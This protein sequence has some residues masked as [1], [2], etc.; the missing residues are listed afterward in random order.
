M[1]SSRTGF[2]QAGDGPATGQIFGRYRLGRRIARGGMAEIYEATL[3]GPGGFQRAVA[4]KRLHSHLARDPTFVD[5]LTDE[6]RLSALLNHPNICQVLDFGSEGETYYIAMERIVGKD[7]ARV[8][9]AVR[10]ARTLVPIPIGVYV[11]REVAVGLAYAHALTSSSGER[12]GIVHRDISPHNIM[13]SDHGEVKICDF[14]IA[15]AESRI[16]QTEAGVLKGKLCYMAPEQ[17]RGEPMDGK[18]D[19]FAAGAVLYEMLTGKE[20]YPRDLSA[21]TVRRVRSA[22]FKPA[23]EIRPDISAALDAALRAAMDADPI[24]RLD[25]RRFAEALGEHLSRTGAPMDRA[26][27]ADWMSEVFAEPLSDAGLVRSHTA[28]RP[29]PVASAPTAILEAAGDESSRV[30]TR[31]RDRVAESTDAVPWPAA[32]PDLRAT[33]RIASVLGILTAVVAAVVIGVLLQR[34]GGGDGPAS[35][36]PSEPVMFEVPPQLVLPA[37]VSPTNPPPGVLGSEAPAPVPRATAPGRTNPVAGQSGPA[38]PAERGRE[39]P[40]GAGGSTPD[41]LRPLG[42]PASTP[43]GLRPL[44]TPGGA[45]GLLRVTALPVGEVLIDGRPAGETPLEVRLGVGPHTVRVRFSDSIGRSSAPRMV[46]VHPSEVAR[47]FFEPP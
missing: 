8:L 10:A 39:R 19:V 15:K 36:R 3:A 13:I 43:D 23:R 37:P 16:A 20:L 47:V 41:G 7:L 31:P 28:A 11:V 25:A 2:E 5:M 24:R 22:E 26:G 35:R 45:T 42:T 14:G 29:A 33:R 30:Q 40:K 6:A 32:R 46:Q 27:L 44:G 18:A 21:E 4:V 12:L 9:V 17:V 1:N 34:G 38:A